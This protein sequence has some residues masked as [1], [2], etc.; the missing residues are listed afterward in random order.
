MRLSREA[1][2]WYLYLSADIRASAVDDGD[3]CRAMARAGAVGKRRLK[4]LSVV[5][6]Q[7]NYEAEVVSSL[8]STCLC[9]A[10]GSR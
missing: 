9:G 10:W 2:L 8:H 3:E 6:L 7:Q 1:L 5:I 4:R